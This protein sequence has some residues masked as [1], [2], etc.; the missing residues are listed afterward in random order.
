MTDKHPI[1]VI[2]MGQLM[3]TTL[4]ASITA[5][6][7][8]SDHSETYIKAKLAYDQLPFGVSY[9]DEYKKGTI[10]ENE[11][12]DGL[13]SRLNRHENELPDETIIAAWNAMTGIAP[14]HEERV[15][16]IVQTILQEDMLLVIA[17][18]TNPLHHNANLEAL[19][20]VL[21]E[22]YAPFM[23]HTSFALSFEHETLNYTALAQ[24]GITATLEHYDVDLANVR[25]GVFH[26]TMNPE[27]IKQGIIAE[28]AL[29]DFTESHLSQHFEVTSVATTADNLVE[30]LQEFAAGTRQERIR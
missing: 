24:E 5:F 28:E 18:G 27:A 15:R 9:I 14:E 17:S 29:G 23:E 12:L 2:S 25:A 11:F 16:A 10:E 13:R 26:R 1:A 8:A 20:R 21:G 3:S 6:A 19:E 4:D 7:E 30:K 22:D